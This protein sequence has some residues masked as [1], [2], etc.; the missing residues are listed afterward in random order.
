MQSLVDFFRSFS[1]IRIQDLLDIFVVT[2]LI[3]VV[4][5]L[6][7][8]TRAVQ[9][10]VGIAVI[11]L[12]Y[13]ASIWAGFQTLQFVLRNVLP[14][15]GLAIIVLFQSEIRTALTH[16]GR[17]RLGIN[18]RSR[19]DLINKTYEDVVLAAT[20]LASQKI[21]ALIAIE[22]NVGL[23]NFIENGVKLDAKLSYDLLISIFNPHS[24]L[25]DG[26][27]IIR[28]DRIAAAGCFFRPTLDPS[29]AKNLG[30]RH[31]AAIGITEDSDAIAIVVSE[32]TGIISFVSDAR[33]VRNLD[34]ARLRANIQ[35]ALQSQ[36]LLPKRIHKSTEPAPKKGLAEQYDR[37]FSRQNEV[38]PYNP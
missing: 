38:R 1:Q 14:Y 23:Q 8:G 36:S 18:F 11:V 24:P 21:G 17:V 9:M 34:G 29:L 31:R 2:V 25:H 6:V 13:Q 22:R 19:T 7:R 15:A 16:L 27:V 5:K 28:H 30:T 20:T 37:A 10:A 35:Q 32:E 26:A 12:I 33:I 3:Y 4:L